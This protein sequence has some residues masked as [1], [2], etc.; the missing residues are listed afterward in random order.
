MREDYF[1]RYKRFCSIIYAFILSVN[2]FELG[3][4][5]KT[6]TVVKKLDPYVMT[7]ICDGGRVRC[8][9]A[10]ALLIIAVISSLLL[11]LLPISKAIG[12]CYLT[13]F[14]VKLSSTLCHAVIISMVTLVTGWTLSNSEYVTKIVLAIGTLSITRIIN[15]FRDFD[16]S[17]VINVQ[18]QEEIPKRILLSHF[19]FDFDDLSNG[20]KET[21]ELKQTV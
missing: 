2:V 18:G 6:N 13:S 12:R 10:T 19:L 21:K 15:R 20:I 11:L 9:L 1:R 3:I 16:T 14:Y 5:F 8:N 17:K 7:A 4:I